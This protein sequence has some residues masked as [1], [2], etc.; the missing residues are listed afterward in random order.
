MIATHC[1]CRT[2][3]VRSVNQDRAGC[4]SLE[5]RCL[6]FVADG[7]GG[8]FEG[9]R[10]SEIVARACARWWEN[11][12][13]APQRPAFL[14]SMEQLRELLARCHEE[15]KEVTPTGAICGTTA[16]LLWISGAEYALFSVGDSRCY[17]VTRRFGLTQKPVQLTHDDVSSEPRQA[18]KL[19]RALGPGAC[20][21]SLRTGPAR[22]G[23]VFALCS[24]GV[25]KFCPDLSKQL[26]GLPPSKRLEDTAGRVT[27]QV[28]ENGAADNYSLVLVRV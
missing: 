5:D 12:V 25:Y 1:V 18:G 14:Q 23:T 13:K 2:G 27:A 21:L 20:A 17:A 7:M 22:R 4:F 6:A 24:D 26:R 11:F 19:L 3:K 10:A 28:E 9:E 8:H 16:V 15:I